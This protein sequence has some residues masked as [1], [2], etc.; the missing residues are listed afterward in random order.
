MSESNQLGYP[1]G[2]HPD[3]D[4][5]SAFAENALP[6]HERVQMLDHLA[7][8]PECRIIVALSLP[9][10]EHP[11]QQPAPPVR[12]PWFAGWRLAWPVAAALAAIATVAIY[13]HQTA[14]T[15]NS[16]APVQI[17]VAQT[18]ASSTPSSASQQNQPAPRHPLPPPPSAPPATSGKASLAARRSPEPVS[19]APA[20]AGPSIKGRN[21]V[22]LDQAAASPAPLPSSQPAAASVDAL[23]AAV[24]TPSPQSTQ[25]VSVAASPAASM[26]FD[27]ITLANPSIAEQK[28][29]TAPP[30][31]PLPSHRPILS[32]AAQASRIL[33]IDTRNAV[34]LSQDA[35]KH[36]KAIHSQWPGHAVKTELVAYAAPLN[37]AAS[38]ARASIGGPLPVTGTI[39]ALSVNG[40]LK[41]RS[42]SDENTSQS[43]LTGKVTDATGAA[44]PGATVTVS[45]TATNSA[46]TVVTGN[47]GEYRIAALAAGA[48]RVTAQA[49][50][51]QQQQL[52]A[53][54]LSASSPAIANLS[55]PVGA[56][57][58]TVSVQSAAPASFTARS[59]NPNPFVQ[60]IQLFQIT[61]EN[62]AHFTSPDGLTWSRR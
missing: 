18:P 16:S 61:T 45:N 21:L 51:F 62:G 12:K 32:M 4:Q 49:P 9:P 6:A 52:A 54:P 53:V 34:F 26:Q 56:A 39:S 22:T 13:L 24:Q 17:A 50:G 40:A 19:S 60:P 29:L 46:Q 58:Q 25:A 10:V 2:P 41:A 27:S 42:P 11:Q 1:P 31:H 43:S 57:T 15:S 55:L 47:T 33:A 35:G 38:M 44:I 14:F 48:Y 59:P 28:L 37:P 36:W 7:V 5:I 3:A 20:A 23:A 8:C 30:P